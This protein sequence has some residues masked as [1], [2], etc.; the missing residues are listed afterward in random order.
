MHNLVVTVYDNHKEHIF[1]IIPLEG[2]L[3]G[4][5]PPTLNALLFDNYTHAHPFCWLFIC[6]QG[7]KSCLFVGLLSCYRSIFVFLSNV[8]SVFLLM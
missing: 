1:Y 7:C 5:Y 3:I 2:G 4:F 6:I 8:I